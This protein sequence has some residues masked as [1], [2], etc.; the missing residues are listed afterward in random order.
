MRNKNW[1]IS[2]YALLI[3]ML[4]ALAGCGQSGD[5]SAEKAAGDTEKSF[6]WRFALEETKGGV[7]WKYA[8][9]FKELMAE[10]TDGQVEVEIYP[11]GSLG[12]SQDLTQQ[13]QNGALQ[14]SFA[15]AGHVGSTIPE[16]QVFT[17][18]FL[19]AD[20]D[21]INEKIFAENETVY[22]LLGEAY[23]EKGLQLLAII[24]EGWMVWSSNDPIR[25]PDDFEGMKTRV[26][27]SP[28]LLET[29]KS[30][31]AIPTPMAY[32]E[33]YGGLQRGQIDA[34]TQPMFAIR[35]MSFYEVQNYLTE[36]HNAHF[37]STVI[38]NPSY[39]AGLPDDI[40]QAVMETK[41]EL[42]P[43]IFEETHKLNREAAEEIAS[44]SDIEFIELTDDQRAAFSER[45]QPVFDKYVELAGPR[46]EKILD[47]I[48]TQIEQEQ[49]K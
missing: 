8:Q 37:V 3:A 2:I 40:Q 43:Y 32:S 24:P 30:Y 10:K 6:T 29:Y 49:A 7:Q 48:R 15:S 36:A 18:H 47:A 19:F 13:V 23:S 25:M 16:A 44:K 31:G 46:G 22:D 11:Y 12:T 34:Q 14:F 27:P 9:K 41:E 20:E 17:L 1:T 39:F 21:K 26:K 28:L 5:E 35:D 4:V 38:T 45:V 42:F 33:I